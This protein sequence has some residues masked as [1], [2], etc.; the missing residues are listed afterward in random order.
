MS[1]DTYEFHPTFSDGTPDH[2]SPHRPGFRFLYTGDA[3]R[4]AANDAYAEMRTRLD[5]RH[6]QQDGVSDHGSRQRTL[7]E[8]EAAASAA[9]EARSARMRAVSKDHHA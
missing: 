1:N 2:T 4:L 7:D 9:Y 3:G 6:R 8:L 5:Y